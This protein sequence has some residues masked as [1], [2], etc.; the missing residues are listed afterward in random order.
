MASN[1]IGETMDLEG[2]HAHRQSL[3]LRNPQLP[4][5]QERQ[6]TVCNPF[7]ILK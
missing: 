7:S 1:L 4:Q 2:I 5:N 3:H 6:G